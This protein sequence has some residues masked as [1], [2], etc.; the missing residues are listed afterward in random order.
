ML[1]RGLKATPALDYVEFPTLDAFEAFALLGDARNT[2]LSGRCASAR[3]HIALPSCKLTVQRT[4]PRI[5]EVNYRTSGTICII[6]LLPSVNAKINGISGSPY[7]IMAVQG[8]VACEIFEPQGNLFAILHINPPL[9]DRGWPESLDRVSVV[10]IANREA[11]QAFRRT[12]ESLLA[13]ASLN[14]L[15]RDQGMLSLIEEALLSSLDEAICANTKVPSPRKFEQYRRIVRQIDEYLAYQ[16]ATDIYLPELARVC[17]VSLRT[18]QT[19]TT[20]VRGLS[21]LQYV[22]LRRLWS[23]RKSLASGR[24]NIKVSD[25]ARAHGFWH[26]SEFSAAYYTIFGER[27]SE[28]ILRK[29]R[30]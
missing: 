6:P 26:L 18:L 5:L 23:V 27:P 16:H 4:F 1:L 14:A 11:L 10:E 28:T 19:A 15:N 2:P 22:R 9:C 24:S 13:L 12:V 25:V 29:I 21:V 30:A 7:R 8:E 3:A 20:A 17:N